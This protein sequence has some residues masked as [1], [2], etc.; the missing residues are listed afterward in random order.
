MKNRIIALLLVV[1][2]LLMYCVFTVSKLSGLVI[3][4]P[5]SGIEISNNNE[6]YIDI[7]N[8]KFKLEARAL[9]INATNKGLTYTCEQVEDSKLAE[10]TINSRGYITPKTVGIVK[11]TATTNEG[12]YRGSFILNV[13]SKKATELYTYPYSQSES[14]KCGD[15][16]FMISK[17]YPLNLENSKVVWSSSSPDV[18]TINAVSGKV[19]C[20]TKGTTTIIA[21][22]EN[23]INGRLVREY[24]LTVLTN[25]TSSGITFNGKEQLNVSIESAEFEADLL[26]SDGFDKTDVE[27]VY[28]PAN[29]KE[30]S[31]L[32][33]INGGY[34]VYVVLQDGYYGLA[35]IKAYINAENYLQFYSEINITRTVDYDIKLNNVNVID[36]DK[37]YLQTGVF[38]T[39][40]IEAFPQGVSG[41]EFVVELINNDGTSLTQTDSYFTI[42]SDVETSNVVCVKMF[43]NS[44]LLLQKNYNVFFVSVPKTLVFKEGLNSYGIAN[45]LAVAKSKFDGENLVD[46]DYQLSFTNSEITVNDVLYTSSDESV[47][48]VINN[49]LKILKDGNATVTAISKNA[50]LLGLDLKTK[51]SIKCVDGVA[52]SSYEELLKASELNLQIVLQNSINLGEELVCKNEAGYSLKY[53]EEECRQILEKE[54]KKMPATYDWKYYNFAHNYIAAP[55]INYC[56]KFTNNVF[57]NGYCLNADNIT[58]VVDSTGSPYSWSV[59]QGPLDFVALPGASV[60]AQD[61]VAFLIDDNVIIDNIELVGAN[62][63]GDSSI[64]LSQLDYVGTV[65]EVVGDNVKIFN[66]RIRNGRNVVRVFGDDVDVNKKI[67]VTIE[68]SI[69]SCAREFLVRLGTNKKIEGDFKEFDKI[70]LADGVSDT[71][72][73]ECSPNI[74]NFQCFNDSNLSVYGYNS[75]VDDMMNNQSFNNLIMSNL[76]L[77]NC[78]LQTS[79]V[80]AIGVESSFAGPALDGGR[81]NS[82]NFYDYGWINL[83]GTS[84]PTRLSLMGNTKILDWKKLENIDSSTLIEGYLFG[85]DVAN[86]ISEI[87]YNQEYSNIISLYEYNE[88]VHTG[89]AMFGG[90]KNYCLVDTT[91][92]EEEKYSNY[93]IGFNELNSNLANMLKYAAGN[94]PFR[95]FMYDKLSNFSFEEQQRLIE[96]GSVFANIE[97]YK[98]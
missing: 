12:A 46:N 57:G 34:K 45:T 44:E 41:L 75:L 33:G 77:N 54:V 8:D 87:S 1:P 48:Q 40:E 90:G 81:W 37:I 28:N 11:I 6:E 22:V 30:V 16:F 24:T 14:F 5:V 67:S 69:I 38:K 63:Y 43:K 60:K 62:L 94:K 66:S 76:S 47:V 26:L 79:G 3:Y 84:Y 73:E 36:G 52:V 93:H 35:N 20:L 58:N 55:T 88:Y 95:F 9:P 92:L 89:I 4:I 53:A 32:D 25:E 15:E 71:V 74:E 29:V 70:N 27:F 7:T 61:N 72:W 91:L 64:N 56:I 51:I 50:A 13:G 39:A 83:A 2:I 49:K 19:N 80:F 78:I 68:S 59:F 23:G 31:I 98:Y 86:M 18:A 85:F 17:V 21:T 65:V 96:D 10:V 97:V 42:K 82:H